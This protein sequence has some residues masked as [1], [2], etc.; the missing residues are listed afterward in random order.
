VVGKEQEAFRPLAVLRVRCC[1]KKPQFSP[2][3][4]RNARVPGPSFVACGKSSRVGEK[5]QEPFG[6][7]YSTLGRSDLYAT[8]MRSSYCLKCG[9]KGQPQ[10]AVGLDEDG[11]AA[12]AM[13]SVKPLIPANLE[14]VD[15]AAHSRLQTAKEEKTD[16][17][18]EPKFC[19]CGCGTELPEGYKWP[20][21]RGHAGQGNG[22]HGNGKASKSSPTSKS[23]PKPTAPVTQTMVTLRLPVAKVEKLFSL[24]LQ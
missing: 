6:V 17:A 18:N 16:M 15:P 23:A 10:R 19:A 14:S 13:H 9:E 22:S 21:L 12:C 3:P 24:L 2:F 1:E 4:P 11:E 8:A 7:S 5:E 20:R